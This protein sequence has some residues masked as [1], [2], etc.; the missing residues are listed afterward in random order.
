VVKHSFL[1]KR[2]GMLPSILYFLLFLSMYNMTF[3][4]MRR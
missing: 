4:S 1:N 2:V 3:F